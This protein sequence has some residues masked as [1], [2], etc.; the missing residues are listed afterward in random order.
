VAK[1]RELKSLAEGAFAQLDDGE[2]FRALDAESNSVAVIAQHLSGNMISRWTDFLNSDGEKPDRDR[3]AEFTPPDVDRA[4]LL[5]RWEEGW[6]CLF[7]AIEA[8]R[9]KDLHRQ[10]YIRYQAHSVVEALTRQLAHYSYHVG[11]IVFL[12]KHLRAGKWK[13]LSIPR[14]QSAAYKTKEFRPRRP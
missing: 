12:S 2:F 5:A 11:Q 4:A 3:D 9:P 13:T 10:I 7:G 6:R 8:L 14:G 1:F